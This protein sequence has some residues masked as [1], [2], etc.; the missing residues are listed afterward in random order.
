MYPAFSSI[1][2]RWRA[3]RPSSSTTRIVFTIYAHFNV[4]MRDY[5]SGVFFV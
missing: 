1:S 5:K 3:I 4:D 2:T